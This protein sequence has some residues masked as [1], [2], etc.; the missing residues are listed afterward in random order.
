VV[1]VKL[2]IIGVPQRENAFTEDTLEV[3]TIG[4]I[5]R[6]LETTYPQDYYT[7]N[8]SLNG[9][10]VADESTRLSDG[11]AVVIVPMMSGG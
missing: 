6:R 2:K 7:L 9:T 8:I 1:K 4:E 5:I 3:E 10:T 11:D